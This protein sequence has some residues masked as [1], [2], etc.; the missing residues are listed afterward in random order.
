MALSIARDRNEYFI[1]NKSQKLTMRSKP[2][3]F[4]YIFLA[5]DK[6]NSTITDGQ[7]SL[8]GTLKYKSHQRGGFKYPGWDSNPEC[9]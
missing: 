4:I 5:Q 9:Q 1:T 6:A 8:P 3:L 2:L 7:Y